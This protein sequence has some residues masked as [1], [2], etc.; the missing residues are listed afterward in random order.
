MDYGWT[1]AFVADVPLS[2]SREPRS[3]GIDLIQASER[4][5]AR[6]VIAGGGVAALEALLALRSF[7]RT[8]FEID[9]V[10]PDADFHRRPLSVGEQI[11][12]AHV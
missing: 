6:V 8:H 11:G 2:S 5:P 1:L 9:L 4:N 3:V 12:R 10:A 7:S